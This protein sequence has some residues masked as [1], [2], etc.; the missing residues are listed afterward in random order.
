MAPNAKGKTA[1]EV[2]RQMDDLE[3]SSAVEETYKLDE[4]RGALL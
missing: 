4:W 2:A 1:L 3:L